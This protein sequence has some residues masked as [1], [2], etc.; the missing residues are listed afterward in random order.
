MILFKAIVYYGV[1]IPLSLLPWRV[2]YLISTC[3][4]LVLYYLIGYRKKVVHANLKNS[5]PN[6]DKDEI[7][8]IQKEFYKHFCDLV[9]ETIKT[10]SLSAD[11]VKRRFK[12]TNVA[13]L[14]EYEKKNKSIIAVIAHYGNWELGALSM[15]LFMPN[16]ACMGIYHPL[17]D[18]FF[19]EKIIQ[20]RSRFGLH[21]IN[22][23]G[24]LK[25]FEE[26]KNK[27]TFTGFIGDQTPHNVRRCYWTTFLNQETPV[28][29]GAEK[30]ARDYNFPVFYGI[31]DKVKRGHYEVRFELIAENPKDLPPTEITERHTRLLEKQIMAKPEYWLWTHRRWKRKKPENYNPINLS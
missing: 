29:L 14:Q 31:V 25:F 20:S 16:Y 24:V 4:Y 19:D 2:L 27:L 12:Y 8:R 5:F 18:Q 26:Y 13:L 30:Y 7:I 15:S 11:E 10:F 21:L 3:F 6:K 9:V 17:K 22:P 28:Y 23:K 1:L